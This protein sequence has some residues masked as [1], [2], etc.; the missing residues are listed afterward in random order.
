MRANM[1]GQFCHNQIY[2]GGRK[3][4]ARTDPGGGLRARWDTL[5]RFILIQSPGFAIRQNAADV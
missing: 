2:S 5:E 4:K 3:K 1:T